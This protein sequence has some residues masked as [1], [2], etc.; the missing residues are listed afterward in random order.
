ML[1]WPVFAIV[2]LHETMNR[3]YDAVFLFVG[4]TGLVL[5]EV[6]YWVAGLTGYVAHLTIE[7]RIVAEGGGM[8]AWIAVFMLAPGVW[9]KKWRHPRSVYIAQGC[10]ALLQA[11]QG[12][13][14]LV[15][16]VV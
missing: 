9:G 3:A 13:I 15:T 10:Y 16:K 4:V 5:H 12:F 6:F 11:A 7:P 1:V 2:F 8:L 14:M